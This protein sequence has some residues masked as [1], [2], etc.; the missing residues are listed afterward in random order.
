MRVRVF[1]MLNYL[2]TIDGPAASGKSSLSSQLAQKLS[3]KWLSTGVFYRA[4]AWV[5]LKKGYRKQG[6]IVPLAG[7]IDQY[8]QLASDQTM[9]V[10][11]GQDKTPQIYT[12]EVDKFASFLASLSTVRKSLLPAQQK[13]FIDNPQGLIAEGRDC[14]TVVFPKAGLKIYLQAKED[15]RALRRASQRG[16]QD[17]SR[18][19]LL[20]KKR[21]EQDTHR[22]HSPLKPPKGAFVIDSDKHSLQEIVDTVYNHSLKLFAQQNKL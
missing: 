1:A 13:C 9:F 10:Y 7:S 21:D 5:A 6:D 2:I 11:K 16:F 4:L 12:E 15:V 20:Q 19:S 18:V 8:I 3:W 14:G 17:V 22:T